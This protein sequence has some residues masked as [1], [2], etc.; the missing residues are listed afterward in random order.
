MKNKT[1]SILGCGFALITIMIWGT[2]FTSTKILL[3]DFKP[4]EILFFRFL[5]GYLAL[6]L[7]CPRPLK[8][9]SVSKFFSADIQEVSLKDMRLRIFV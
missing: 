3:L 2:T 7:A 1:Q 4:V 9:P 6:F 8:L 5:L